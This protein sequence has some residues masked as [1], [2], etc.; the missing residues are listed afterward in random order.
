[1]VPVEIFLLQNAALY[2][3]LSLVRER[4]KMKPILATMLSISGTEL[5]DAEKHLLEK[6]NPMGITLFKRNICNKKQVKAL[7][8]SVKEVVGRENVLI[9]VDQE[10]GRV[11]RFAPPKWPEYISQY[12][13]GALKGRE[14]EEITH[15]HGV[16]IAEELRKLGIN[17]N[18]SP[19]LDVLY[20]DTTSALS[21][22]IFSSDEKIVAARGKILLNAYLKNG[23]CP[24]IKHMPGHGRAVV[25]PHLNLPILTQ[26]LKDLEKDFYPFHAVASLAP[27]GMTAHIVIP[28]VDSRPVTQ[29]KKAIKEIIRGRIGFQG[30]LISDA[31]DMKAL[32]G[33]LTDRVQTSLDAGCDAV[34]YCFGI[35]E[36]LYEV[37]RAARPLTDKALER[38]AK[39]SEIIAQKPVKFDKKEM[40]VRYEKLAK[41]TQ[42]LRTDYDAV[43]VLHKMKGQKCK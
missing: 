14:G 29:S 15:L 23:I 33:T 7:V 31:I 3:S 19:V 18:Y 1:M 43:E 26:G 28:E 34:C 16:L 17:W 9:A 36:E 4:I 6:A 27:A 38:F 42:N 21:S 20:P 40:Y 37:I 12:A 25:D 13:L 22:R 30:F 5:T 24:C 11:C 2:D 10:G 35:E 39:I 41:K 32:S 8:N